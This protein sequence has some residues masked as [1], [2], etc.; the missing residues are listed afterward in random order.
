MEDDIAAGRLAIAVD[1]IIPV[2]SGHWLVKPVGTETR[3][4][5]V[6]FSNWLLDE[7]SRLRWNGHSE[8]RVASRSA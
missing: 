3:R 6:A 1:H 5:I 8:G 4:E 2:L 7:A